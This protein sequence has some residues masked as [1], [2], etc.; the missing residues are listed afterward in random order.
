MEDTGDAYFVNN[1]EIV[2]IIGAKLM[3]T[4][5]KSYIEILTTI[6]ICGIVCSAHGGD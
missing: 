5:W 1:L 2:M 3:I 6:N 4:L